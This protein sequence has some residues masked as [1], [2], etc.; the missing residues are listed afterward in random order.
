MPGQGSP[1]RTGQSRATRPFGHVTANHS[2]D[3]EAEHPQVASSVTPAAVSEADRKAASAVPRS[4]PPPSIR[5]SK[6]E[7][8]AYDPFPILTY[9][10]LAVAYTEPVVLDLL[11]IRS[12][13]RQGNAELL[14]KTRESASLVAPK[15]PS[16]AGP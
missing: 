3:C 11:I 9:E 13:S 12:A 6:R 15:W 4:K 7:T 16:R 1:S 8:S 2:D 5:R 14:K 10:H